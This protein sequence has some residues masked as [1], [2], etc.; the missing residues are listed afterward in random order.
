MAA[1]GPRR[2]VIRLV[3]PRGGPLLPMGERLELPGRG[4]T[5]VRHVKGPAGSPTLLLLHG[6]LASG[7]LNWYRAFEPLSEHFSLVAVDMRGHG[8]GIRSSRRFT[9]ADCAGDA[10]AT[11]DELG[12]ER[13]IAVGYSLGGPVAQLL[14]RDHRD[15]VDG[16]VLCS[17]AH[18]LVPGLREQWAFTTMMAAAAGTTRAGQIVTHIPVKRVRNMLPVGGGRPPTMAEWARAEM[19]R[20]STRMVLE[21]GVAMSNYNASR[22]IGKIDVPTAVVVTAK[23]RAIPP[24]VQLHLA[25]SVSGATIHRVDDGHLA[26]VPRDIR[27]TVARRLQRRCGAHR[28]ASCERGDWRGGHLAVAASVWCAAMSGPLDGHPSG[29]V[30]QHRADPVLR[31]VLSDMGAEVVRVDKP[32]DVAAATRPAPPADSARP[33]PAFDRRRPEVAR[34]RRGRAAARRAAPTCSIEGFRPGVAERLGIGPD[35]C[36]GR[37]PRLVYGRHDRLGPGRPAGRQGRPRHRL[38]RARRRAQR[39][40]PR[41]A[42]RRRRRSTSWATSAGAVCCSRYGIACAL[43]S[44]QRTGRARSSTPR[45]STA[46]R[47]S[48]RRSTRRARSASGATSAAPTCSTPARPSTTR[49]SAPTA[50]R[51][52]RRHRAAVL[53]R[54]PRRPRPVG[55]TSCPNRDDRGLW[56]SPASHLPRP[57]PH[58][59][60][61]TSGRRSSRARDA[62]VTPI[63]TLAEAPAIRTTRRGKHSSSATA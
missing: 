41:R 13:V 34:R 44:A 61:R 56:T 27:R 40:R 1:A 55:P 10:A 32:S 26:C 49:T 15:R 16:L 51:R 20:H 33:G 21:A 3:R 36:L 18:R 53:R 35:D 14:W 11:L 23:D 31:L 63:L 19:R 47:C 54:A 39:L 29:G 52:R 17:T 60:P 4:T 43:V 59:Y 24:L 38:H 45:W 28:D 50:V 25:L 58:P 42:S 46:P 48:W 57:V 30:G 5:F 37:N 62:C 22:W 12:I 7:G 9:L 8:R 6:W 2:P